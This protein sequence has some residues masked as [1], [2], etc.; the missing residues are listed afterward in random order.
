MKQNG[1]NGFKMKKIEIEIIPFFIAIFFIILF[2]FYLGIQYAN[3][4]S[5]DIA[6]I[7]DTIEENLKLAQEQGYIFNGIV[8]VEN[9]LSASINWY[10]H[11]TFISRYLM[12]HE[13]E[14]AIQKCSKK[15]TINEINQTRLNEFKR[16]MEK[17]LESNQTFQT[18]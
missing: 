9:S 15:E 10:W 5:I 17:F 14:I 2:C 18:S 3:A 12:E 8:N 13:I 1:V 4:K 7:A 6:C 11:Y 16:T